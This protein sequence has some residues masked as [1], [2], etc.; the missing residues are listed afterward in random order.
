[1]TA[2]T[3]SYTTGPVMGD[4]AEAVGPGRAWSEDS[5]SIEVDEGTDLG[6]ALA[7]LGWQLTGE[8]GLAKP[9]QAVLSPSNDT[10]LVRNP[11]G[12]LPEFMEVIVNELYS[13][14]LADGSSFRILE[15]TS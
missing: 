4:L 7:A 14:Q 6:E 10:V 11:D 15:R 8:S 2:G 12:G 9:G 1:M 13:Q 5:F 3:V